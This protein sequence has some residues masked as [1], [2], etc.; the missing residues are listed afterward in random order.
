MRQ[1]RQLIGVFLVLGGCQKAGADDLPAASR[2]TPLVPEAPAAASAAPVE[3]TERD[4]VTL[5]GRVRAAEGGSATRGPRVHAKALRAWIY[6]RPTGSSE[7]LGYLRAGA[8]S[9]TGS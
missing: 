5:D 8:S 1:A 6:A 9:P 4:R 7:R 3:L 2:L